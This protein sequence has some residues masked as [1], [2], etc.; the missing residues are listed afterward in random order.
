[1]VK[2]AS[3]ELCREVVARP[4]RE[5]READL[6]A[7]RAEFL[8]GFSAY[9]DSSPVL[10][11]KNPFNYRWIGFIA[12]ALP[13]ARI[14]HMNRDPM[15]V[16]WSLYRHHFATLGNAFTHDIGDIVRYMALHRTQMAFWREAVP[17]RVFD[18][19]YEALTTNPDQSTRALANAV[20]LDWSEA[21][22]RPE[23]AS[24]RVLTASS[25]QVQRPIYSGSG[26]GWKRYEDQLAPMRSA[27]ISAGFFSDG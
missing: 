17:G 12:A 11:D 15:A 13:E 25:L 22:L 10:V 5:L 24:N 19:S 14:V 3:S 8:R 27:L 2:H 7:L 4:N 23:D 9:S 1:M 16:A 18:M 6:L 20:G 21:W 26:E